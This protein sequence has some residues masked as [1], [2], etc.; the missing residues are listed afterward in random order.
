VLTTRPP[1]L[2]VYDTRCLYNVQ[3]IESSER[4][5]GDKTEDDEETV[6]PLT[7]VSHLVRI[8]LL[9]YLFLNNSIIGE[10]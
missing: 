9:L 7:R 5:V 8:V 4:V 10:L 2:T 3:I 1:R 6:A